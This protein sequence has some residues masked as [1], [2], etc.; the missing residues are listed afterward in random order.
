MQM[1]LLVHVWQDFD[2]F[3]GKTGWPFISATGR[4][5]F[6]FVVHNNNFT[7]LENKKEWFHNSKVTNDLWS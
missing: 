3:G 5:F 6:T 7:C 2:A 4:T 1:L